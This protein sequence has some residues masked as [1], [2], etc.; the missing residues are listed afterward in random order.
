M[1]SCVSQQCRMSYGIQPFKDEVVCDVSP[2]D[3]CDVVLGQ[4][5]MWK[6]HVVYESRPRSVIITLG[7]HL[8]RIPEVVLTI[9]PPKQCRKVI[10]H[11][12]KFILFTVCSKDAQKATTTTA[13]STPSIQQKQI[14][15]EKEDIVSSPTMVP[16]QCPVKPRDNRLVEQIQPR[17][18]QVR[19][20]L[21]QTKQHN[22][23]NKAHNSPRFRFR[24]CFP[25]FPGHSM[26][27]RPLLPKGGGLIQVDIGGH[28]PV[29]NS[30]WLILTVFSST[31]FS[32]MGTFLCNC[33]FC[34]Y[35]VVLKPYTTSRW[36]L[37][38]AHLFQLAYFGSFHVSTSFCTSRAVLGL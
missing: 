8:Y 11:T 10:S 2:L 6:R 4:P 37:V 13:A 31:R 28:P 12:A 33:G 17:Q 3:V 32:V 21:P 22:F 27:W 1:R 29:P 18:Q 34:T 26:Q 35:G 25:L 7:G 24:K 20:N 15:E 19:D 14:A 23:S 30:N 5:Y 36:I 16:T 38:A 9:V